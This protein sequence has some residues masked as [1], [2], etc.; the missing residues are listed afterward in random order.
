ME[1]LTSS[2]IIEQDF[3]LRL[4]SALIAAGSKTFVLLH[5]KIIQPI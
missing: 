3:I 5:E 1:V 2:K 4:L